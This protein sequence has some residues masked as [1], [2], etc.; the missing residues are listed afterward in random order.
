VHVKKR[1]SAGGA[2]PVLPELRLQIVDRN[3]AFRDCNY[4]LYPS[5]LA[6]PWPNAHLVIR[7]T[8]PYSIDRCERTAQRSAAVVTPQLDVATHYS[9]GLDASAVG[10]ALLAFA[11]SAPRPAKALLNL[12]TSAKTRHVTG[13]LTVLGCRIAA[14]SKSGELSTLGGLEFLPALRAEKGGPARTDGLRV[15]HRILIRPGTQ[16]QFVLPHTLADSVRRR[17]RAGHSIE[18]IEILPSVFTDSTT[19]RTLWPDGPEPQL[20]DRHRLCFKRSGNDPA[21]SLLPVLAQQPQ[22][23]VEPPVNDA[24]GLELVHE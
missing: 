9:E 20:G 18:Q 3:F 15:R 13:H 12:N 2:R 22:G 4:S 16:V 19:F 24:C 8:R 17:P 10:A 5:W 23:A 1:N 6:Y 7:G 21:A 11:E 14:V